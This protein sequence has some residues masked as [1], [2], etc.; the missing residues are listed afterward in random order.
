MQIE[1]LLNKQKE[2]HKKESIS[3]KE[4]IE[5]YEL[6]AK[7]RLEC[8]NKKMNKLYQK[9]MRELNF[10][11]YLLLFFASGAFGLILYLIMR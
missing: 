6:E 4:R 1:L 3:M 9:H 2:R 10:S 8:H 11:L 5:K 7:K